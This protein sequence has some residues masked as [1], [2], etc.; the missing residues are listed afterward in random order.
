MCLYPKKG[1]NERNQQENE[2]N[3][4]VGTIPDELGKLTSLTKLN[5]GEN[6]LSGTIPSSLNTLTNLTYVQLNDN[7]LEGTIPQ[8]LWN[9][10]TELKVVNLHGSG[11]SKLKG[12]TIPCI[13]AIFTVDCDSVMCDCITNCRCR[14]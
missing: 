6:K 3:N 13:A 14:D 12:T 5:L 9:N 2:G 1:K 4:L 7:M 11:N 10:M 8:D